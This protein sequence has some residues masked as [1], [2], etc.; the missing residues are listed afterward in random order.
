[1]VCRC[2]ADI[3]T[4]S[5]QNCSRYW[6]HRCHT[7][8]VLKKFCRQLIKVYCRTQF[9]EKYSVFEGGNSINIRIHRTR[10]QRD[11]ANVHGDLCGTQ[12]WQKVAKGDIANE[13]VCKK[14]LGTDWERQ[15]QRNKTTQTSNSENIMKPK[16]KAPKH[17]HNDKPGLK[18]PQE[19]RISVI[20][21][22]VK[23]NQKQLSLQINKGQTE[24]STEVGKK[25]KTKS[26]KVLIADRN[27]S[28][29][30][31]MESKEINLNANNRN[32]RKENPKSESMGTSKLNN[33]QKAINKNAKKK[34]NKISQ[35]P[36]T[37]ELVSEENKKKSV[38]KFQNPIPKKKLPAEINQFFQQSKSKSEKKLHKAIAENENQK[39]IKT[40]K[41][42]KKNG[43]KMS[44]LAP[45]ANKNSSFNR[46][47]DIR[48]PKNPFENIMITDLRRKVRN[49]QNLRSP[50]QIVPSKDLQTK[51]N[52]SS[53]KHQNLRIEKPKIFPNRHEKPSRFDVK[54]WD[55][56]RAAMEQR[57]QCC[58]VSQ[59]PT[60][61]CA[62]CP[63]NCESCKCSQ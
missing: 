44:P 17:N 16:A 6:N 11:K 61:S 56:L 18:S 62:C 42:N 4:S 23:D 52:M 58:V 41:I 46:I 36:I 10:S 57:D 24:N 13:T 60:I 29:F 2:P 49:G 47:R 25:K 5:S 12:H 21:K 22:V 33:T 40:N 50:K 63:W 1:M 14:P 20:K 32:Q 28:V 48:T 59:Q 19:N 30:G 9:R 8:F 53:P 31:N 3:I 39:P 54:P 55:I 37:A 7:C 34:S 27:L 51:Q 45:K 35:E 26:Q 43:A 38:K 15:A